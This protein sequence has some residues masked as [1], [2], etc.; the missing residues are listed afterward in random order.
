V[1]PQ[2]IDTHHVKLLS[3]WLACQRRDGEFQS[4]QISTA[5]LAEQ[6]TRFLAELRRGPKVAT[7]MTYP[8]HGGHRR[9]G[10]STRCHWPASSRSL[11][12]QTATFVYSLKEPLFDLL[13]DEI[14]ADAAKLRTEVWTASKLLDKLGLDTVESLPKGPRGHHQPPGSGIA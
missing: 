11:A 7:S 8:P 1:I 9:A 5:G 12:H 3:G 10:S 2:L 6:S 4:G 14:G 13:G